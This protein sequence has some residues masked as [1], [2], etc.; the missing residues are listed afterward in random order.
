MTVNEAIRRR[1]YK[2]NL[3]KNM[4]LTILYCPIVRSLEICKE[5]WNMHKVILVG[6]G[7]FIGAV[8]RYLISGYVQ[9]LTQSVHFP[10]GTLAVNII[11][12]FLIGILSWLAESQA[13]MTAEMRVLLLVG[14]L[15]SFTTY[16]TFSSE[17]VNLLQ[18]QRLFLALINIG[19]HIV[20]G[21]LAVLLG[22]FTIIT[23]WR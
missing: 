19:T 5:D 9:T 23:I 17:T 16:S 12:C 15:G 1:Q 4:E 3:P 14:I 8:L 18:D 10:Y 7:G 22:R 2:N 20:L 13:G 11:G 21:L 6:A